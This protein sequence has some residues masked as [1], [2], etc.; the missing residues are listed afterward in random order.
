[1]KKAYSIFVI[2]ILVTDL[3]AS[4]FVEPAFAKKQSVFQGISDAIKYPFHSA[5]KAVGWDG[6]P[7]KFSGQKETTKSIPTLPLWLCEIL[8]DMWE[9]FYKDDPSILL[10]LINS[11]SSHL[12]FEEKISS[13]LR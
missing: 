12:E 4:S 2:F 6:T 10:N 1:M 9:K 3:L 7:S 5:A 11:C 13:Y 8:F